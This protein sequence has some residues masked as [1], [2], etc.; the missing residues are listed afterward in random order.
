VRGSRERLPA[1][2]SREICDDHVEVLDRRPDPRGGYR[3]DVGHGKRIGR[4]SSEWFSRPADERYLSP[5]ELMA[6]VKG[7]ADRSRTRTVES[8]GVR[9]EAGRGD[10]ERLALVLPGSDQPVAPTQWSFGQ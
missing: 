3:V 9:V 2:P 5:T 10:A 6:T 7:R 4:V 8:A 1:D